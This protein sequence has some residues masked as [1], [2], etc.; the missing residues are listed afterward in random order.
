[1]A[2]K[3][4]FFF[5][6]GSSAPVAYANGGLCACI[7][8]NFSYIHGSDA[9]VELEVSRVLRG[10]GSSEQTPLHTMITFRL[11]SARPHHVD[12]SGL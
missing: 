6:F 4:F 9:A 3:F 10:A 1:M 11:P 8:R 5:F 2:E 7:F 12:T